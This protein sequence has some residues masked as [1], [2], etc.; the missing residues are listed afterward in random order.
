LSI[1]FLCTTV[2]GQSGSKAKKLLLAGDIEGAI[3]M[4]EQLT[5]AEPDNAEYQ[6]NLGECYIRTPQKNQY[7]IASLEKAVGLLQGK[8][9]T[10]MYIDAKFLLG[11]ALHVNHRFL[12]ALNV[13]N[14]LVINKAYKQYRSVD[15]LQ[16]EIRACEAAIDAY[17][18]QKRLSV[19][20]LGEGVN[21]EFTQ[22][23]PIMV[24]S[25]GMFIYT[26][27]E[28]TTFRDEKTDDGEYD[29]NIFFINL[30]NE[31]DREADPFS[32]PLNS[33]DNE[34]CCWISNDGK[35]MLLHKDGDIFESRK[36][37]LL[38]SK[39]EKFDAVNSKF[40][41]THA[42]M[43][44]DQT[45]VYFSSD[46]PGG[47]GG[48]DIYFAK[49]E[50]K[51]KWS[52]PKALNANVNTKFD[53]E[54]PYYHADGT[55][56]FSSKGHNSIGGYDIFKTTGSETKFDEPENLGLPI[57]SIE[58]DVF[59]FETL[60]HQTGYFMSKRPEGRGR[61]DL[62]KI[63]YADTSMYYL[64]VKGNVQVSDGTQSSLNF[65][66]ITK[67]LNAYQSETDNYGNFSTQV[68]RDE[69]YFACFESA[70]HF[71]E[72]LTFSAPYSDEPHLNLGTIILEKIDTAKVHKLYYMDFEDESYELNEENA[73]FLLSLVRFLDQ[74]P[75]LVINITSM[76]NA[77]DNMVK[78]RKQAAID[79]LKNEGIGEDRMFVDLLKYENNTEDLLITVMAK[80]GAT[81]AFNDV[82]NTT[83]TNVTNLDDGGMTGEYTIQLGAFKNKLS[84]ENK[85]FKDFRGKVKFR[86]GPDQLN[87]YTYGKYKFKADAE[88]YLVTVHAMGFRDAFIREI[89]WYDK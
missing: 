84:Y 68:M 72:A 89:K 44:E 36:D 24:E 5:S 65:S 74:N 33:K 20:S 10:V 3:A 2:L 17:K 14:E 61:G 13:Y 87:H 78:E 40:K 70:G 62:F 73:L 19:M 29:E 9:S 11:K 42:V 57:N 35:Y 21:T 23:S 81:I 75:G 55:L 22:H 76:Q 60:D 16:N 39:P 12:D 25:Y 79:F 47:R 6:M 7:A 34:A 46:R 50:G 51:G 27:K 64:A 80:Q 18:S 30:N 31:N 37:G 15:I 66:G 58:D 82:V 77:E 49:K 1:I 52:N 83:D 88:K 32:A 63:S 56:Y 86:T 85:F 53:E 26:S 54:A 48:K 38:W 45:V 67:K 4:Y 8:E 69:N 71:F 28:K 59:Y 43:N 41:E